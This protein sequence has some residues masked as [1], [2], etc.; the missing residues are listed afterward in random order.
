MAVLRSFLGRGGYLCAVR[1][2]RAVVRCIGVD[3]GSGEF[4]CTRM[5]QILP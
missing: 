5:H 2:E 4:L 3:S 1:H